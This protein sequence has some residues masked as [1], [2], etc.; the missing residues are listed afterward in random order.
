[1]KLKEFRLKNFRGYKDEVIISFDQLTVFIGRNDVGKSTILEA[2]HIFFNDKPEKFDLNVNAENE[3]IVLTAVFNELPPS[4][5]LDEKTPTSLEDE[6]LVNANGELEVIKRYRIG[7]SMT[8]ETFVR[9]KVPDQPELDN[10]L[11]LKLSSL[12]IKAQE[13]GIDLDGV[14]KRISKDVRFAIRKHYYPNG[15]DHYKIEKIKIDG[16]LD[17]EDNLKKVWSGLRNYL[18]IFSLFNVDKPLNDQDSDIQDPM[19]EIIKE[20]LQRPEIGLLLE[21]LKD[22][23]QT[24]SSQLADQTIQKLNEIDTSLAETLRSTFPKEPGK[25]AHTDHPRSV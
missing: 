20:V 3:Y 4:L 18:P 19:K 24:A 1:M 11:T 17:N 6:Y 7:T 23:I 25:N 2:L 15:V 10:L 21:D 13:L 8:E 22:E 16:K 9:C 5:V 14:D 12:K